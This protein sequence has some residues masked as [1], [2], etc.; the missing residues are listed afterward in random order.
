MV[1]KNKSEWVLAAFTKQAASFEKIQE[2]LEEKGI[3]ITPKDY[4][5]ACKQN[6]LIPDIDPVFVKIDEQT[7]TLEDINLLLEDV[8]TSV[9]ERI[10]R[11]IR[12]SPTKGHITHGGR[13][14]LGGERM[15]ARVGP[16]RK[17]SGH[18]QSHGRGEH[19]HDKSTDEQRKNSSS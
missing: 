6:G 16:K 12:K 15:Q 3:I 4:L 5:A 8:A 9:E 19:G 1:E 7:V 18:T 14:R 13:Q 11:R 10:N 17:R 2:T